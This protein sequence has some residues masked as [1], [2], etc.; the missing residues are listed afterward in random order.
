MR[1]TASAS[2][3][4]TSFPHSEAG[5][6]AGGDTLSHQWSPWLTDVPHGSVDVHEV[7]HRRVI[8][9]LGEHETAARVTDQDDRTAFPSRTDRSTLASS[10]S[11]SGRQLGIWT[12]SAGRLPRRGAG[13]RGSTPGCAARGDTS[14]TVAEVIGPRPRWPVAGEQGTSR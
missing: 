5:P 10:I 2:N 9:D 11:D 13:P 1:A 12:A 4:T 7:I 14:T 3:S 6:P 8:A